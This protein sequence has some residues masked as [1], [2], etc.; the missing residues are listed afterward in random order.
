MLC[1]LCV[2]VVCF[3]CDYVAFARFPCAPTVFCSLAL[4]FCVWVDVFVT[5]MLFCV[6]YVLCVLCGLCFGDLCV[7]GLCVVNRVMRVCVCCDCGICV[8][9]V[10]GFVILSV[11]GLCIVFFVTFELVSLCFC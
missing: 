11:C 2:R 4:C 8:I 1:V 9:R 3:F 6:L 7:W 10:W 5:Y